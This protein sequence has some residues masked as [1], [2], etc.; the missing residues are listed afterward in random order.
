MKFADSEDIWN[1][2][3]KMTPLPTK[4]MMGNGLMWLGLISF[5][6]INDAIKG[7]PKY[8]I[9]INP[10]QNFIIKLLKKLPHATGVGINSDIKIIEDFF[11]HMLGKPLK[12]EA[13]FGISTLAVFTGWR[14]TSTLA[15]NTMGCIPNKI[16]SCADDKW[17]R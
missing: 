7:E 15:V 2:M 8:E 1:I 6:V 12:M 11:S 10:V 17:G 4:I 9:L 14:L 3:D 5:D 16:S 13:P